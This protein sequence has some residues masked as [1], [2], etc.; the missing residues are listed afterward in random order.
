MEQQNSPKATTSV[1]EAMGHTVSGI[2][3]DSRDANF[4]DEIYD[5]KISKSR[6]DW[7]MSTTRLLLS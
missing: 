5:E 4:E 1:P 2:A 7:K 3:A 6:Y